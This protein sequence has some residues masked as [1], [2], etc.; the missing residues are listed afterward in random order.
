M[1]HNTK[2]LRLIIVSLCSI[3]LFFGV[4]CNSKN[5]IDC[6][7]MK[8]FSVND[9]LSNLHSD[10]LRLDS[11]LHLVSISSADT[12]LAIIYGEIGEMY[13][14]NDF[15]KAKEYYLKL[16][17]LSNQ[18]SWSKGRYLFAISMAH[19]LTRE[20]IVDSAIAINLQALELAMSENNELWMGIIAY[21]L[22]NTYL[23]KQW[24]ET[25]L[26]Y[27][28]EALAVFEKN[29]D[30]ERL[31]SVYFQLSLLYSDIDAVDKAIEFGKKTIA[32]CPDDPYSI[33]GLAKAYSSIHQ[34]EKSNKYLEEALQLSIIQNNLYLMGLIYYP[35]GENALMVFDLEKAEMYSLKALEVN[36]QIGN[37][38]AYGGALAILSK[39][40]ELKGNFTQAEKYIKEVLEI[41]NELDNLTGKNF[42]YIVLSELSVAQN[43]FKENIHYWKE[44]DLVKNRIA[45]L[46]T[47]RAA[48]EMGVK[49]ETTK[50]E[51]EIERQRQVIKRQ[52]LQRSL[53]SGGITICFIL[54]VSFWYMFHLRNRR[55][56]I[57]EELNATKDRFFSI[58]SHDLK[59]PALAQRDALQLLLDN[60]DNWDKT[61]VEK[62]YYE[63]L[64]TA[65]GQVNLLYNLLNWAQVQ[66]GRMPYQPVPFDL[67]AE[68][69]KT[70]ISL[71]Y[72]MAS[73][74]KIDL[75]VEI[76]DATIITGDVN[77]LTTVVRNLLTNAIKFTDS[78][79]KVILLA[80][81]K[82]NNKYII[83]VTD[84]GT[85]M[86]EEQQ[87]S[88]FHLGAQ[89][90][91]K[92]TS[93][94]KGSG[95]GLIVCKELLEKHGSL[96]H[97][98]CKINE[99]CC[100]W[101]EI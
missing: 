56:H 92:G 60:A 10:D 30:T 22:G 94:E 82:E 20:G 34:Y 41:V 63:L 14:D 80:K 99:G 16:G 29:K 23:V 38:A 39:V 21:S 101:F 100:F 75:I 1:K 8:N 27:Y 37:K 32:L 69:R 49:Y 83:S 85:G 95:I 65:D 98:E 47:L 53:L 44:L 48:G 81:P 13:E 24:H 62:F 87:N 54:F 36:K 18:L 51:L 70:D 58:I 84:T 97:V 46:I 73:R 31:A 19:I 86:S 11:L 66:T 43:R 45:S 78:G 89:N 67:A 77:M 40:E 91:K 64:K 88:L 59:N 6:K 26:N 5:N 71:L 28:M 12:N 68:L 79:G 52:N 74:K 2:I 90:S 61:T 35:L 72:N 93:G 42:C 50:K 33:L 96:L 25:A 4:G 55:N 7:S 76:P 3:L 57:L 15:D 9:T 17:N